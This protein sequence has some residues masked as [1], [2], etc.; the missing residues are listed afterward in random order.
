MNTA[1]P[2]CALKYWRA[3]YILK[4]F[5]LINIGL[6]LKTKVLYIGLYFKYTQ[7]VNSLKKLYCEHF[8][9]QYTVFIIKL[10]FQ[11][12]H[13]LKVRGDPDGRSVKGTLD[14]Y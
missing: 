8:S 2:V 4:Y 9:K 3:E 11:K 1:E 14:F 13:L 6:F 7:G 12:L 10:D 5:F